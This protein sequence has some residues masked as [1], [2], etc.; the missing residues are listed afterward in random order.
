MTYM[1]SVAITGPK[2]S[3]IAH[4]DIDMNYFITTDQIVELGRNHGQRATA[5]S[6]L[7][8][9]RRRLGLYRV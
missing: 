2:P 5:D 6:R 4:V 3:Y 7:G 8:H 1:H 9:G